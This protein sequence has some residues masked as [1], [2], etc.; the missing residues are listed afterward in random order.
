MVFRPYSKIQIFIYKNYKIYTGIIKRK[1][2]IEI[3]LF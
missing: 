1:N 3:K 2:R